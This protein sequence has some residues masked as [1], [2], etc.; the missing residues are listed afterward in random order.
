MISTA[1]ICQPS[2][3]TFG[4]SFVATGRDGQALEVDRLLAACRDKLPAYMVPSRIEA[5][6]GPLPRNANGKIDRKLLAGELR[7]AFEAGAH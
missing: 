7:V 6:E 3:L 5:R 2:R 4:A 1:V